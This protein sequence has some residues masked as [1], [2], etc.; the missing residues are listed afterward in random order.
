M[1]QADQDK[2]V[3]Y[4]ECA[5]D[6]ARACYYRRRRLV[7]VASPGGNGALTRSPQFASLVGRGEWS[8]ALAMAWTATTATLIETRR[9][10]R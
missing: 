9:C 3:D 10:L 8:R 1:S 5:N 6:P 2:R 7:A 4:V